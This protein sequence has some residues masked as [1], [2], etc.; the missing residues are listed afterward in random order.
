MALDSCLIISG[1]LNLNE[2]AEYL[3]TRHHN[4]Y[5][6]EW[7]PCMAISRTLNACKVHGSPA[8]CDFNYKI[9]AETVQSKP[10]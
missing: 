9:R 3:Y 7:D 10:H 5:D 1:L 6:N 8:N 4:F 2:S